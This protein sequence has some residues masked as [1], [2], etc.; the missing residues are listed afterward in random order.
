MYTTRSLLTVP[1]IMVL[2]S[3]TQKYLEATRSLS[4]CNYHTWYMACTATKSSRI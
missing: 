2:Y 3:V 1:G 4:A